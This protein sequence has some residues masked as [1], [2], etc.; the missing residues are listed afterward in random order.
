MRRVLGVL[1]AVLVAL[2][3]V[4]PVAHAAP[5]GT[6]L[7]I[8]GEGVDVASIRLRTSAGCPQQSKAYYARLWGKGFP[9][10]GQ[11]I[12][13]NT[14]AGMRHD[15]G[16]DVYLAQTMKDFAALAGGVTLSGAYKISVFCIDK[17]P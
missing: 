15:G 17:F 16:F 8:P 10:A 14:S 2:G 7:V 11:V 3:L 5:T 12:T 4:P 6:V 9:E 13:T 1:V